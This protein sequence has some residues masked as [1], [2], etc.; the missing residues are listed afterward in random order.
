MHSLIADI[1]H[2][3]NISVIIVVVIDISWRQHWTCHFFAS[4]RQEVRILSVCRNITPTNLWRMSAKFFRF[5][6]YCCLHCALL[7]LLDQVTV[8]VCDV[9]RCVSTVVNCAAREKQIINKK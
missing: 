4:T 5:V 1:V 8:Y 7:S 6:S 2:F 3:M 9:S